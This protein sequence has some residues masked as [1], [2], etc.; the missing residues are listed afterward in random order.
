MYKPSKGFLF[1]EG[2]YTPPVTGA[3][4]LFAPT[5]LYSVPPSVILSFSSRHALTEPQSKNIV[6]Q[7]SETAGQSLD[8]ITPWQSPGEIEVNAQSRWSQTVH[9]DGALATGWHPATALD[10]STTVNHWDKTATADRSSAQVWD[11]NIAERDVSRSVLWDRLTPYDTKAGGRWGSVDVYA[12][13]TRK[14]PAYIPDNNQL[15]FVFGGELYTPLYTPEAYFL[16]G[17]SFNDERIQPRDSSTSVRWVKQNSEKDVGYSLLWGSSGRIDKSLPANWGVVPG[18]PE[19]PRPE[20]PPRK[21]HYDIMN[22][23]QV[24]RLPTADDPNEVVLQAADINLSLD[25]DSFIWTARFNVLNEASYQ[26]LKR[27]EN[28]DDREVA[29]IINGHRWELV[30]NQININ[31]KHP[32]TSWSVTALSAVAQLGSPWAPLRT[33]ASPGQITA[34]QAVQEQLQYTPFSMN[35]SSTLPKDLPTW[36]IPAG[37][38]SYQD[39]APIQ[40]INAVVQAAGGVVQPSLSGKELIIQKRY[41]VVPWEWGS[42]QTDVVIPENLDLSLTMNNADRPPANAIYV[43]G[44]HEGAAVAVTAKRQNTAG[45]IEAPQVVDRYITESAPGRSRAESE[46]AQAGDQEEYS[47]ETLLY[48]PGNEMGLILPGMLVEYQDTDGQAQWH[49]QCQGVNISAARS[50][51]ADVIQR[52][53]LERHYYPAEELA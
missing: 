41:P 42:D 7:W 22:T 18:T 20:E 28:G 35:W 49:A 5:F 47:L 48:P 37:V 45:D 38:H 13:G 29:I 36:L 1:E 9:E 32:A 10:D 39:Q 2:S 4:F 53:V 50:G 8:L 30:V 34:A 46:L 11:K 19:L 31:R 23:V 26:L 40:I 33:N 52:L 6:T 12:S 25:R 24:L 14:K 51:N 27:A 15:N 21:D 44:T 16:F 17:R 43:S 3:H